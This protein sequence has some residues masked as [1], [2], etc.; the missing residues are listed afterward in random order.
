MHN[1]VSVSGFGARKGIEGIGIF[2]KFE[3]N[4]IQ[5]T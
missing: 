1:F 3:M 2:N 5:V 4:A